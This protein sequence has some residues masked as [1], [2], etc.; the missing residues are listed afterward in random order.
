MKK[1][2][3]AASLFLLPLLAA[4]QLMGIPQFSADM[5]MKTEH[6]REGS[7]QGKMYFG[8]NKVRM[9]M[10]TQGHDMEMI[11]DTT[12]KTT[13]MIMPQQRMYM[14]MSATSPMSRRGPDWKDFRNFDPNNPCASDPETTCKKVGTEEV[15]GR[16]CDKWEFTRKDGGTRTVWI[17]QKLH[18]PVR[19][20]SKDSSWDLTNV[21]EGKQDASLFT[22]PAGFQKMDLGSMMGGSKPQ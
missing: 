13:Y 4:A 16:Q 20:V 18:F 11:H 3:L 9:D 12:T 17:D 2:I 10:S 6:G 22:V 5:S 14:E 7:M 1:K 19:V 21:K 15:N 8:G